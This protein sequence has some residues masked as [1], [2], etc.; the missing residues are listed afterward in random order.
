MSNAFPNTL[1]ST[2][3]GELGD[4]NPG[5]RDH[6]G[7]SH[8]WVGH[9]AP[10]M[11]Y[12]SVSL[13]LVEGGHVVSPLTRSGPG[14]AALRDDRWI[15]TELETLRAAAPCWHLCPDLVKTVS[16]AT[17]LVTLAVCWTQTTQSC[18]EGLGAWC[19]G[20]SLERG[21]LERC[22]TGSE[23]D[24][25]LFH[26]RC[27]EG[28]LLTWNFLEKLIYISWKQDENSKIPFPCQGDV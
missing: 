25:C 18:R 5:S 11:G 15:V 6:F 7:G 10:Q 3:L 24:P 9:P 8:W 27:W 28:L 14:Q 20:F 19:L 26:Q 4:S 23:A 1:G 21:S 16:L 12:W 22:G 13:G 17:R 2:G